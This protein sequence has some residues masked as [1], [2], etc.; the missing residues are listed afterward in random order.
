MSLDPLKQ[1]LESIDQELELA[2]AQLTETSQR[3][4][5]LLADYNADV[6]STPRPVA[7]VIPITT[8]DEASAADDGE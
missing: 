6:P 4:D 1:A 2:M 7:E 3:V 5:D 8:P